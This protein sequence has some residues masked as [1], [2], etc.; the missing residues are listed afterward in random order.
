LFEPRGDKKMEFDFDEDKRLSNIEKHGVDFWDV[1]GIF[2]DRLIV[3]IDSRRDYGEVRKVAYGLTDGVLYVVVFTERENGIRI[4][5]AWKGGKS[6]RA[7]YH[8]RD[9]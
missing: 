1:L 9:P 5:S 3:K 2:N 8:A 4:I 6:E 7:A